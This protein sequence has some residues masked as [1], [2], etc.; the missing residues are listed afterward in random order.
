M[1]TYAACETERKRILALGRKIQVRLVKNP[2]MG[3]D[4]D[5]NT[6]RGA[7]GNGDWPGDK[8]NI[9]QYMLQVKFPP[10]GPQM[11]AG[12]LNTTTTNT[13]GEDGN[14][15]AAMSGT[16]FI[17]DDAKEPV[18]FRI[19]AGGVEGYRRATFNAVNTGTGDNRS[20]LGGTRTG[21]WIMHHIDHASDEYEDGFLASST[22]RI[23]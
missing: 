2:F 11:G 12:D 20:R 8:T 22:L 18:P 7:F 1:A 19:A 5:L 17:A 23:T 9:N 16:R 4:A 13:F 15:Y 6:E 21:Q 10:G 14:A 3:N